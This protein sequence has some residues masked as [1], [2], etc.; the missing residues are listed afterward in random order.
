MD[1]DGHPARRA[2]GGQSFKRTCYCGSATGKQIVSAL[3]MEVRRLEGAG[4]IRRRLWSCFHSALIKD[5]VC[6]GALL[7]D[8]TTGKI[9]AEYADALVMAVGGQNA[10]SGRRPALPS[11]T[12]TQPAGSSARVST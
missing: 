1:E 8:E 10:L 7:F 6:Y 2:F 4:M 9:E 3:V 11:A 5:G 12:A